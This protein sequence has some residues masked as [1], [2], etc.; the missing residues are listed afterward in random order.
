MPAIGVRGLPGALNPT[1]VYEA[2]ATKVDG[3]QSTAQAKV[4][5]VQE[6]YEDFKASPYAPVAAWGA[7]CVGSIHR[8]DGPH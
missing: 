5:H 8:C 7:L 6:L 3:A 1:S 4:D 2:A